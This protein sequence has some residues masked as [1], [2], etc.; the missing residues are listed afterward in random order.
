[1]WDGA[2][3]EGPNGKRQVYDFERFTKIVRELQPNAVIFS[4]IGPDVRWVGN[5]GG[6]AGETCWSMLSPKGY[7]RGE[8]GPPVE[9]LNQGVIDGTDWIPAEC[10]VS[11]RPGW[12]YHAEQ[13]EHVKSLE[14]LEEIWYGSVGRNASLLL[15]LPVDRRGL[16]HEHDAARLL[17][18]RAALDATFA[19]NLATD[20]RA[21][22]DSARPGNDASRVLDGDRATYCVTGDDSMCGRVEL[23][24]G[25]ERAFNR[26]ELSE[27]I[28]FG[29]RVE[30]FT[31]S[32]LDEVDGG[33]RE[34][35]RGTTIGRRRV[36]RIPTT[37]ATKIELE[38]QRS[39]GE[40]LLSEFGLYAAPPK[41]SIATE[42][43]EFYDPL[44]VRVKCDDPG[45][46][47]RYTL[48][49]S[50]PTASSPE[51]PE[52]L[53]LT[54]SCTLSVV[55]SRDGAQSAIARAEFRRLTPKDLL[56]GTV[57]VRAPDP[58]LA[59]RY[60]EGGWQSLVDLDR[61]TPVATGVTSVI[62]FEPAARSEH[63]ALCWE[64]LIQA[65]DTGLFRVALASDDGARL[66]IDDRLVVD[67]D[68]LHGMSTKHGTIGLFAGLHRFKLAYFNATGNFGLSLR[69]S[70]PKKA[71]TDVPGHAFA[72]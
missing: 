72:H 40:P 25:T 6:F 49:G 41:V 71:E 52:P 11:I 17:E 26:I 24:L 55:A 4:D 1:W 47:L 22:A 61:A 20:A 35:A 36:L 18:L 27:P 37:R 68:G 31:V 3:G 19:Q 30:A 10:D 8:G 7:A 54:E 32:V 5:E 58:G 66:W 12:Y 69:W 33:W 34:L 65:P 13:D 59:W 39:R 42:E 48:D 14:A 2:C 23:D 62:D 53:M 44:A 28:A 56:P 21:S 67:H 50:V 15:N 29:Q 57:F 63:F 9:M 46:T 38:I 70:V 60:F 43:R 45:A 64:G 51:L 16:V